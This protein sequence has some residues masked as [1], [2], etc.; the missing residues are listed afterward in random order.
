MDLSTLTSLRKLTPLNQRNAITGRRPDSSDFYFK[1]TT[2]GGHAAVETVTHANKP[3]AFQADHY[4]GATGAAL[5]T[6]AE[7]ESGAMFDW[8]DDQ[9]A[10][11]RVDLSEYPWLLYQLVKCPN[12]VDSNLRPVK[13]NATPSRL[14]LKISEVPD[15]G[16]LMQ[17]DF[18]L[19]NDEISDTCVTILTDTFVMV[20]DTIFSLGESIGENFANLHVLCHEFERSSLDAFLSIFYTYV[21]NVGLRI[22]G[23]K[24]VMETEAID[25]V[26]TIAIE[27]I[28]SDKALYLRLLDSAPDEVG[29]LI[30]TIQVNYMVKVSDSGKIT[31]RP[32]NH[33]N[34]DNEEELLLKEIRSF[35]PDRASRAEVFIND[36]LFIVP[37]QVASAFLLHGLPKLLKTYRVIGIDKL[38]EY[39]LR[40]VQPKMSVSFSSGIDYL[41]GSAEVELGNERMTLQELLDQYKKHKYVRLADGN[42]A[43]IDDSYMR[44][45]QRIFNGHQDKDGKFKI[46]FFDLPEIEKLLDDDA[47][48]NEALK[49]PREFY[50]GFND[51]AKEKLAL[52]AVNAIVRGYQTEGVKWLKY[53]YDNNMGG[54]LADDMGLGKTLQVISLLS[55]VYPEEKTPSLVVMP[56]SLLFNWNSELSRFIPW[57]DVATYYGTGRDLDEAVKHQIILTT[58]AV[59][60]NDIETLSKRKFHIVVLDESQTIKNVSAQQTRSVYLLNAD[61]RFALSGTP[62]EN[63]LSELYSLFR[64]INPSMFG[65]LDD[66]NQRYA[67]PIQRDD[68]DAMADLRRK[69]FPFILRRLKRDV[70]KDLPERVEQIVYVD[71]EPAQE[72]LYE[73][74]RIYYRERIRDT[75]ATEGL[76]KS[77]FV[78]LQA[79]SELRQAASVPENISDG[80]IS[81]AK[82]DVLAERVSEAAENGHKVVVFFNFITGIEILG[83]R[84]AQS[85]IGY[86]VMTGATH[87]R[88]AAVKHFQNDPDCQVFLMTLKT[89]G[90]GLNLTAADIVFIAEPWWNKAAEE[91][92]VSRLHRIGQKSTVFSFSMITHNTIEEKI[93]QLQQMKTEL[94]ANIISSDDAASSK[95]LSEDDINFI[96]G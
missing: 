60:R 76:H 16:G 10:G 6:M 42:I 70:L 61:H 75:I 90:V 66:F 58:Y 21:I 30:D 96:L 68:S 80:K 51:L 64:F 50:S 33:I 79:M 26:P 1:I 83:E 17:A 19:D 78:M 92:A 28:D 40:P 91:Q 67:G 62:I 87:N 2:S 82:I 48:A 44:R 12:L 35:A 81:S 23:Y 27:K 71:M 43:V 7:I 20:G 15:K 4:S 18:Q 54:C 45:L 74:R 29:D 34:L 73:Q 89:G 84:L 86:E 22:E 53:L 9:S 49:R 41:E 37:E 95:T 46:S 77:R 13:V 88:S 94:F 5:R 31:V 36:G 59:V 39:K 72:R 85:G 63:N 11:G 38:R 69:I 8:T 52:P 55:L 57:A 93:L 24:V 65:S 56:R 25:C 47:K 32:L 3:K 14:F